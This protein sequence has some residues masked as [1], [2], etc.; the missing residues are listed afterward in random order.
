MI[1]R[2]NFSV[3]LITF[4]VLAASYSFSQKKRKS[5]SKAYSQV[6]LNDF[7]FRNIGPAFLSGKDC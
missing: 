4:F 5:I 3:F 7:N 6:S 1:Y 2:N